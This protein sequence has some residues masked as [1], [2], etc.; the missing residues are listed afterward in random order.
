MNN[1][2]IGIAFLFTLLLMA[3][4]PLMA[5]AELM[6][7]NVGENYGD[8]IT[9]T[10]PA[11]SLPEP[12]T[13]KGFSAKFVQ[14]KY[15]ENEQS[16]NLDQ[17]KTVK[18]SAGKA[19][20][21]EATTYKD[22]GYAILG[23]RTTIDEAQQVVFYFLHDPEGSD[24]RTMLKGWGTTY[25]TYTYHQLSDVY[26]GNYDGK[27][28]LFIEFELAYTGE[29]NC[30]HPEEDNPKLCARKQYEA[31]VIRK[32]FVIG[33]EGAEQSKVL[34]VGKLSSAATASNSEDKSLA[35]ARKK[36]KGIKSLKK[37]DLPQANCTVS[38]VKKEYIINCAIKNS[39]SIKKA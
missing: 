35:T 10:E 13:L 29:W 23:V 2:K 12:W 14:E 16:F 7:E 18:N 34:A 37:I 1:K 22:D 15:E 26:A 39:D 20:Y 27:P 38:K 21:L 31:N 6:I 36:A 11:F 3:A 33:K 8:T 5:S 9:I 28:A 17:G 19:Y 25:R 30:G 32:L 4:F 24:K